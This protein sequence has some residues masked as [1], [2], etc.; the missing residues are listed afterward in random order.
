M[1]LLL[2]YCGHVCLRHYAL[3][4][5]FAVA[6][7]ALVTVCAI[8]VG[9]L[10]TLAQRLFWRERFATRRNPPPRGLSGAMRSRPITGLSSCVDCR[11]A[12]GYWC[13]VDAEYTHHVRRRRS[14]DRG[15]DGCSIAAAIES[16]N[17]HPESVQT[18]SS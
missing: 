6:S 3:Q 14:H 17:T 8:D 15:G 16:I 12:D 7:V 13:G 5:L 18:S 2:A 4:F 10:D 1:A 11:R 9:L